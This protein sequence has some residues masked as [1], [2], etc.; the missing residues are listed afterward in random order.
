[1][2]ERVPLALCKALGH[3]P[4]KSPVQSSFVRDAREENCPLLALSSCSSCLARR[5]RGGWGFPLGSEGYGAAARG[6]VG[7][8]TVELILPVSCNTGARGQLMEPADKSKADG[9][10]HLL[11]GGLLHLAVIGGGRQAVPGSVDRD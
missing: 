4:F 5:D 1:M 2:M 9:S 7:D 10:V 3:P 6:I 8:V 11:D